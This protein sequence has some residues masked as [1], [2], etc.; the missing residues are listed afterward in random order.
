MTEPQHISD[1]LPRV[2]A[3]IDRRRRRV[4][5]AIGDYHKRTKTS[6][7]RRSRRNT[8]HTVS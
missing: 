3:D 7:R 8:R 4:L 5:A 6:G 2:M 1:I